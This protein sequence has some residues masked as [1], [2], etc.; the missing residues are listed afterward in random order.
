MECPIC[1]NLIKNS[2]TGLCYHHFCSTCLIRWCTVGGTNC[3]TCK[4]PIIYIKQDK[5]FDQ[6]NGCETSINLNNDYPTIIVNYTTESKPK[7]NIKRN[8]KENIT[9]KNNYKYKDIKTRV[10][11]VIISQL[12]ENHNFYKNGLRKNDIILFINNIPCI[13]HKQVVD[14]I[15]KCIVVNLPISCTLLKYS[16]NLVK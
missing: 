5:E 14:I 4:M 2:V 15:N 10:P 13:D 7:E 3:P 6:L 8:I 16:P 9:I 11:G 12:T 1:Y